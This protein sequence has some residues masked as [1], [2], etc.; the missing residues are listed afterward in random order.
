MTYISE[1]GVSR[2]TEPSHRL[3]SDGNSAEHPDWASI[4]K[5]VKSGTEPTSRSQT[6][7]NA[8]KIAGE[9]L[10]AEDGVVIGAA[11]AGAA[12]G[13]L[14]GAVGAVGGFFGGGPVGAAAGATSGFYAGA[15]VFGL[16]GGLYEGIEMGKRGGVE[17]SEV[18]RD[19]G[20]AIWDVTHSGPVSDAAAGVAGAVWG[21]LSAPFARHNYDLSQS[22]IVKFFRGL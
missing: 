7:A 6:F 14:T 15:T 1:I 12:G 4:V 11:V 5:S 2:S 8:G 20:N 19:F 21:F 18:G 3:S 10:G 22:F 9:V 16:I 13:A 17:G